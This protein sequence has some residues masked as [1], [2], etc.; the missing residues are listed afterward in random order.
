MNMQLDDG[1]TID[2]FEPTVMDMFWVDA[3]KPKICHEKDILVIAFMA[4]HP[5]FAEDLSRHIARSP[6]N[7]VTV[8]A[9]SQP[10]DDGFYIVIVEVDRHNQMI[11][12]L[13]I[14]LDHIQPLT[15]IENWY[16]KP[17][18]YDE[19]FQWN[20]ENFTETVPQNPEA[21]DELQVDVYVTAEPDEKEPLTEKT[22]T[23]VDIE[24]D[25]E[26]VPENIT[27]FSRSLNKELRKQFSH[28]VK[29]NQRL[30]HKFDKMNTD[31]QYLHR[32]LKLYQKR[33]KLALMRERQDLQR[34]RRLEGQLSMLAITNTNPHEVV[35]TGANA[36]AR[37]LTDSET[38]AAAPSS[39]M[40]EAHQRHSTVEMEAPSD[41]VDLPPEQRSD[42]ESGHEPSGN[43]VQDG[44]VT[45]SEHGD[46]D[47]VFDL[48]H[49]LEAADQPV[50]DP[51]PEGAEL[52]PKPGD[53]DKADAPA[54]THDSVE[55]SARLVSSDETQPEEA[56]S[57]FALGMTALKQ[58]HY[59]AAIDHFSS[60]GADSE[61]AP[62]GYYNLAVLYYMRR[63]FEA[64]NHYAEIAFA[65]GVLS[66]EQILEFSRSKQQE[67]LTLQNEQE[68]A[69]HATFESVPSDDNKIQESTADLSR[70]GDINGTAANDGPGAGM[71]TTADVNRS[72]AEASDESGPAAGPDPDGDET[73]GD[74]EDKAKTDEEQASSEPGGDLDAYYYAL[75][76][77]A[78]EKGDMA[79]A[80]EY[81]SA[82]EQNAPEAP[83]SHYYLAILYMRSNQYQ[84]ARIQA[85]K[86]RDLG[87]A[88][89][90]K[91]IDLIAQRANKKKANKKAQTVSAPTKEKSAYPGRKRPVNSEA[92]DEPMEPA[93]ASV[94]DSVATEDAHADKD[95]DKAIET[96]AV[97]VGS[98]PIAP[99]QP[100]VVAEGP[101]VIEAQPPTV[102]AEQPDIDVQAPVMEEPSAEV[103]MQA[104]VMEEPS[105]EVEMQAP[106]MEEPS[107]EVEMQAPVMEEPSATVEMQAP[108]MEEPLAKVEMQ[109]PVTK[110]P[111][112]EVEMQA[113]VMEEPPPEAKVGQPAVAAES[114][115]IDAPSPVV[116]AEKTEVIVEAPVIDVQSPAIETEQ[117]VVEE[118]SP[119]ADQSRP[120]QQDHR[121]DDDAAGE[122]NDPDIIDLGDE[123]S[124]T[125]EIKPGDLPSM[126]EGVNAKYGADSKPI[127]DH[128]E[129]A[130]GKTDL[131]PARTPGDAE[132]TGDPARSSV[133]P[134]AT[135][136]QEEPDPADEE[137]SLAD[138][139]TQL[140]GSEEENDLIAVSEP[141]PITD[142]TRN[143]SRV[144]GEAG[145]TGDFMKSEVPD[146]ASPTAEVK[147]VP[148][149]DEDISVASV[150]DETPAAAASKAF[151]EQTRDLQDTR[152]KS[153]AA[154][155]PIQKIPEK[156]AAG[157]THRT[158]VAA[159]DKLDAPPDVKKDDDW[160][161]PKPD[162][163]DFESMGDLPPVADRSGT[164]RPEESKPK[165][166]QP[167]GKDM[168]KGAKS[169]AEPDHYA[170]GKRALVKKDYKKAI[171]HL[172]AIDNKAPKAPKAHYILGILHYRLKRPEEAASHAQLAMDMG[173]SKARA[174]LNKIKAD[175]LRIVAAKKAAKVQ[176][177]DAPAASPVVA[178]ARTPQVKI[179]KVKEP[180]AADQKEKA[181]FSE[182]AAD[183][184]VAELPAGTDEA[185]FDDSPFLMPGEELSD[186]LPEFPELGGDL[187][188]SY[189]EQFQV[190]PLDDDFEVT[191]TFVASDAH[192]F[193]DD[194]PSD[195]TDSDASFEALIENNQTESEPT[196]KEGPKTDADYFALGLADFEKKKYSDALKNLIR[197]KAE[198]PDQPKIEY[199]LAV[200]CLRLKKYED[201]RQ[202]AL[203]AHRG[204]VKAARK[205]LGK[206][207]SL[208][209]AKKAKAAPKT[210]KAAAGK[211]TSKAALAAAE[212]VPAEATAEGQAVDRLS[213][214]AF[215]SEAERGPVDLTDDADLSE[216]TG[217]SETITRDLDDSIVWGPED[218]E[219]EAVFPEDTLSG[220][221]DQPINQGEV[222]VFDSESEK[223]DPD[224][225]DSQSNGAAD[226]FDLEATDFDISP[227]PVDLHSF[228][229]QEE[230]KKYLSL[231]QK[232]VDKKDYLRAIKHFTKITELLPKD[233]LGY[234]NL[235]IISYR[236]NYYTTAK[237]H[238]EKALDLGLLA[239]QKILKKIE[240]KQS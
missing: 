17:F 5:E 81:F 234:Y 106:V 72:P 186:D 56:P 29:I 125:T 148:P 214:G 160:T 46:D 184:S 47:E 23:Y 138:V 201:A 232:A 18:D 100:A 48:E 174:L 6:A 109:A 229:N 30:L 157:K 13:G 227:P 60:I 94:A 166:E 65:R 153:V 42:L 149:A 200:V 25:A 95:R 111:S 58:K 178:A 133:E 194:E 82:V 231:G 128:R 237:A 68:S 145:D 91:I 33:E 171:E 97:P 67:L 96:A 70:S 154:V 198:N 120:S 62:R 88:R 55:D 130:D 213:A 51:Q 117:P 207:K 131:P 239:S 196:A 182:S 76:Q 22:G 116:E 240:S 71:A 152:P 92:I 216:T 32:Q 38:A 177:S 44:A 83:T 134:A 176:K 121:P 101:P 132:I 53:G 228:A 218:F 181:V 204:G 2:D 69:E 208:K 102:E 150:K 195:D 167:V 74:T 202:Y 78:L 189:L 107:A 105:A 142:K 19:Y 16:F 26:D 173:I 49:P 209:A 175:M 24:P 192:D 159:G 212:A 31:Y 136:K 183:E 77:A 217:I 141:G 190:S 140:V 235:A 221:E 124:E 224:E 230:V 45:A 238:A 8:E 210:G 144:P 37:A 206:I 114:P 205:V 93:A 225:P 172:S 1:R 34:I 36:A 80:I 59:D 73:A 222:M 20:E 220:E 12:E 168:G 11:N 215:A 199:S 169:S 226:D 4:T 39:A 187:A 156:D 158:T 54:E 75:G 103:E 165:D 118:S 57:A 108:V 28:L 146:A 43:A 99:V 7:I 180:T 122:E 35:I 161:A 137:G 3:F 162:A 87:I 10:D 90:Q 129:T 85:Q 135:G 64:A 115:V 163:P 40:A 110:E 84:K 66:A 119:T 193:F 126:A 127:G 164:L 79:T 155:D 143:D 52:N 113:P 219:G 104:P 191:Q 27:A 9:S 98:H 211:R 236:L 14:L 63:N 15:R 203:N 123:K 179:D 89:A 185:D 139:Y 197:A 233:P 223:Q 21:F 112:A 170:L 86:A 151:Y 61:E 147:A 188:D 41:T 50:S